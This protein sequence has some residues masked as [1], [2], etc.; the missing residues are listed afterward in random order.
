MQPKS[1]LLSLL[2]VFLACGRLAAQDAEVVEEIP[3]GNMDQWIDR[4]IEES[5]IIGGET[6]LL[7]ELG[8]TDLDA[9]DAASYF[10]KYK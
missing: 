7:Y 10:A 3:F 1:Y 8:P 5:G 9:K 2:L 6:K 4:Q